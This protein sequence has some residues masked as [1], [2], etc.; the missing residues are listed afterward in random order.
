MRISCGLQCTQ[1]AASTSGPEE[2]DLAQKFRVR[3]AVARR[4]GL[5]FKRRLRHVRGDQR[6]FLVREFSRQPVAF[7]V[8]GPDHVGRDAHLHSPARLVVAAHLLARV[9]DGVL[10]LFDQL[11][12]NAVF[13]AERN[14]SAADKTA[15]PG[16][17]R[18]P[19]RRP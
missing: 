6:V 19:P 18:T 13:F 15:H 10:R 16:L 2:T 12:R 4:G 3:L 8:D 11:A 7:F 1:C 14:E 17:R 9:A 5:Q